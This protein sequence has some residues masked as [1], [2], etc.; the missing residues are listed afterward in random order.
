MHPIPKVSF[1]AVARI[2][3]ADKDTY[4][5][6]KAI[7][8]PR[9]GDAPSEHQRRLIG[10]VRFDKLILGH[11]TAPTYR[12]GRHHVIVKTAK[13]RPQSRRVT[14][15]RQ[16]RN[17]V[18]TMYTVTLQR[19]Q[20]QL[21]VAGHRNAYHALTNRV[22]LNRRPCDWSMG[23]GL[24]TISRTNHRS[25]HMNTETRVYLCTV[26]GSK[27]AAAKTYYRILIG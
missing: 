7:C 20:L 23:P 19:P 9:T 27:D 5:V 14:A 10:A 11:K 21:A 6:Q 26:D 25:T 13:L 17:A 18:T 22:E 8:Q 3:F 2:L 1:R 15:G 24:S 16:N 4:R 12:T